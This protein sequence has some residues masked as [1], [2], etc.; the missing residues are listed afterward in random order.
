[1]VTP[2]WL[3][4]V[5]AA[6]VLAVA[7]FSAARLVAS[8]RAGV[9]GTGEVDADGTHVLM[10]VA[11]AG[12]LKPGLTTLPVG[13][14]EVVFLVGAAWFAGRAVFAGRAAQVRRPGL[15]S[16]AGWSKRLGAVQCCEYPVPHLIDCVAMVYMFWAVRTVRGSSGMTATA[17]M[18]AMGGGAGARLPGL[19]LAGVLA[20]GGYVVWL[21]DRIQQLAPVRSLAVT[22][23]AGAMAM[24][25]A[26]GSAGSLGAAVTTP[27]PEG[28]HG[29]GAAAARLLAPRAA[30]WCKIAMGVAMGIM[31]V[32]LL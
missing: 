24:A 7:L 29:S 19:A 15:V 2:D 28:A 26:A 11:M 12:M 13:V 14:W 23:P 3:A 32:D 6:V 10:G 27:G 18:G 16:F 1:V 4:G 31:L 9:A 20:I 5:L 17:G 22:A 25:S 30:T 21:G 8:R